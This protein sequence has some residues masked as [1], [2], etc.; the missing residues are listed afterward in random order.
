MNTH[1]LSPDLLPNFKKLNC[2]CRDSLL[3][4]GPCTVAKNLARLDQRYDSLFNDAL[5]KDSVGVRS[6]PFSYVG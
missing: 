3:V 6:E 1:I 2:W 5:W 4:L